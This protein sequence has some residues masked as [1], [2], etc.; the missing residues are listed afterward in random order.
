MKEDGYITA[1]EKKE[2][3]FPAVAEIQQSNQMAGANGYLLTTVK[4]E[5]VNSKA[6]TADDLETGATRSSPRS[7]ATPTTRPCRRRTAP[8]RPQTRPDSK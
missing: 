6:F 8:C 4:N 3:Q 5:L 2:A 1:Q 7:T